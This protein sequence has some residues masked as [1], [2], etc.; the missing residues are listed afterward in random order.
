MIERALGACLLA[1][2]ASNPLAGQ[3][4][5]LV[6]PG[7]HVRYSLPEISGPVEAEVVGVSTDRIRVRP[8]D[9]GDT[10]EFVL[11]ASALSRLEVRRGPEPQGSIGA[12]LGV[13]VGAIIGSFQFEHGGKSP[14]VYQGDLLRAYLFAVGCGAVGWIIGSRVHQY[15]WQTVPLAPS[16]EP[17]GEAA[18]LEYP[19]RRTAIAVRRF[20][21]HIRTQSPSAA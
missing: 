14:G 15:H 2:L 13:F 12:A 18:L 16:A 9:T 4:S 17:S 8:T 10:L 1:L 3:D 19:K 5:A 7:A 20:V 11:S 6:I 21:T